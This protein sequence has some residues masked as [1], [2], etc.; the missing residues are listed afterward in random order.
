MEEKLYKYA[1]LLLTKGVCINEYQ[2]LVI[3]VPID[4]IKFVRILTKVACEMNIKDIYYDW[5]DEDLKHTQLKYFNEEEIKE[6]RFWNKSVHDEY[7]KKDAA[8]L[9]LT[10]TGSNLMSDIESEKLKIASSHSLL[11]R[12][13][14]REKQSNNEID[15]CIAAVATKQWGDLLFDNKEDSEEKLW[16]LIFDIC[17]IN[18][19]NPEEAWTKKMKENHAMCEKLTNLNIKE[20]HYESSNGTN[21]MIELPENAVWCGGSSQIKGREPI[22]NMPTE[23]VFTTPNKNKTNGVVYTS[24]PLVHSGITI[25]DIMLEFKDGKIVN[26]DAS[27]GKEELK[28]II[29]LDEESSMLG[30]VALVDKNSKIAKTN[31]LF[32]E[33][34]YDENASCHIAVG[35]GFKECIKDSHDMTEKEL[36]EIGYNN[37]KNHVDMMIGTKDLNITAITYDNKEIEIFKD[38]SFNV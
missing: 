19:D 15:W 14:Y 3:N 38:G 35:R 36:E 4:A 32:Y 13:L 25:K 1:H 23:E 10:S 37:S 18:T 26:F 30:E 17:L 9:H 31:T 2:P 27:T 21:L 29:E 11:T 5:T 8:F 22:V 12:K 7:A 16:E 28:N 6:S 20:L 24:L 33:T 34:L